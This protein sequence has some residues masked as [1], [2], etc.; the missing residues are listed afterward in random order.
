M[1]ASSPVLVWFRRDL[2][3]SDHPALDAACATGRPV[4]PV[5]VHDDVSDSLGAAPKWRLGLGVEDFAATLADKGSRLILRRGDALAQLQALIDE[6]GAGAVFWSR[7]YDPQSVDRDTR[8]KTTLKD[9]GIEARSFG[10]HLMFEPWSVETGQGEYYKVYTPFWNS[11]KSRDV[12]APLS[13]PPKI[14]APEAW[15]ESD[16]LDDWAMGAAMNRGADVVR[17]HVRLGES[18]AQSRLGAFMANIVQGYGESRDIPG[19]DGTSGLS[20]NLSLGEISPHQCWHAG[21]RARQEGKQGAETFLKELVWREFA[22]H[23]MHHTPRILTENWREKWD[24]FPWQD[25]ARGA[26]VLAWKKGRT[27][28]PFVD[29]AMREMYVTGRMHNRGRMIVASYLTKH[30][31]THWRIGKEW[32][33]DCLIDWDPASNA[34]GWQ[35]AAGSGP[36]A[37]PYF[38]VF[39]PVTQLDKFDKS[40]DYTRAWIAEGRAD[41]SATALSF[42]DAVPRHWGMSPEDEYPD[43]IMPADEGRKRAL[44]A[45]E[46]RDF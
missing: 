29:A 16:D 30:L 13:A 22:Y 8:V 34:M 10:G 42:F 19:Q 9:A 14:P 33:E 1:T 38:R 12:D 43:P 7:L 44:N 23:L 15:P 20:E 45:Y 25:D 24:S 36:D 4:I 46:N 18:A 21:Q 37:T 5:F 40:R 35:W 32:F 26:Q 6:T 41:P 39:N 17:P 11:V 28:I 3:L 2:R 27:G 31:M